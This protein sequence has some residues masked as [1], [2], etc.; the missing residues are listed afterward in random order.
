[1]GTYRGN[2]WLYTYDIPAAAFVA[3]WNMV[4]LSVGSGSSGAGFL[5]PGYGYDAVELDD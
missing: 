4:Q 5:S 2:N 1:M 3:G